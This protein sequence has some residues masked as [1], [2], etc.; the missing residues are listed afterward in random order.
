LGLHLHMQLHWSQH[1]LQLE[2]PLLQHLL[3]HG[4]A[5]VV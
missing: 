3:L 4:A 2:Q 5:S 1:V